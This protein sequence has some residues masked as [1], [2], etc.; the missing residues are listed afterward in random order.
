[1]VRKLNKRSKKILKKANKSAVAF[2][3]TVIDIKEKF[4]GEHEIE[5]DTIILPESLRAIVGTLV[6][7]T[8]NELVG[9]SYEFSNDLQDDEMELY[10][11][12][13]DLG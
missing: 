3:V 1:M 7:P 5:A 12:E 8:T 6:N 4:K 13:L 9:M 2:Y 10:N 11:R